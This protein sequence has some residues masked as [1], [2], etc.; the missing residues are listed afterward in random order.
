MT[1]KEIWQAY[2]QDNP[3]FQDEGY[4]AWCYGSDTPD[5]LAELTVSGIKTATASAFPFY[6]IEKCELPKAGEHSVILKTDGSAICIIRTTRV[7]V[8]PF[9][10]VS[11]EHAYKEGEGDRSLEYWREV[12]S[13]VFNKELAEAGLTFSE[14]MPVVCEEFE[15]VYK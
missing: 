11:A 1:E 8:V 13:I 15:L 4:E 2:V 10:Q 6:E 3:C 9:D 14:D 7:T 12:H 5:E